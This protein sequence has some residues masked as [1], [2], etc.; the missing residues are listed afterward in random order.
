M[1]TSSLKLP[2]LRPSAEFSRVIGIQGEPN[3]GKTTAAISWPNPIVLNF[4]KKLRAGIPEIPFWDN[5]WV[6]SFM[7]TQAPLYA[8][9]KTALIKWIRTA[10]T[11]IPADATI[12][13]D[14]FTM[15]DNTWTE[16]VSANKHAFYTKGDGGKEPEYNG[17]AM[18]Y[19]KQDYLIELFA[20]LRSM[21]C[22]VIVTFHET[23][24]R[25]NKGNL[26][27][28]LRPLVSG[29]SFKDQLEGNLGMMIRLETR[30]GKNYLKLKSDEH[31]D[32]MIPESYRIPKEVKE[33]D[34]TDKAVYAELSKFSLQTTA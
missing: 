7:K 5:G 15:V 32:A 30:A 6:H 9:R 3:S 25:D 34:V 12:I 26:N 29:G 8:D 1:D 18:F 27:N 21:P 13:L 23:P 20:L 19:A 28:K 2:G 17:R 31:F 11:S 14:S 16:F 4:D 10:G 33:L 22:T 24:A